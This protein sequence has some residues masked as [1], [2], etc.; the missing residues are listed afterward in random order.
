MVAFIF[1]RALGKRYLIYS[2]QFNIKHQCSVGWN[3]AAGTTRAI[4]H[5]RGDDEG[6]FAADL[7]ACYTLIPALNDMAG[8]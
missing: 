1:Y 5:L 7:H 3:D 8:A 4:S 2:M 6:A